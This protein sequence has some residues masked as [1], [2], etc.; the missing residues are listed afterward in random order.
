MDW[1]VDKARSI[2][3][4][5]QRKFGEELEQ[6]MLE[7]DFVGSQQY[8]VHHFTTASLTDIMRNFSKINFIRLTIGYLLMLLHAGISLSRWRNDEHCNRLERSQ[9]I[10]GMLGV[11]LIG[12]AVASGLGVCALIGLSFNATTTQIVPLL[13]SGLSIDNMF[14]I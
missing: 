8:D 10:L 5:W 12:L 9:S 3:Q 7:T 11:L 2:L 14:L 13:A 4:A 1:S 6:F